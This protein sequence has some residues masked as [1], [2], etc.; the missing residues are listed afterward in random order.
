M[1]SIG[2]EFEA[3]RAGT[4]QKRLGSNQ[5]LPPFPSNILV[6]PNIFHKSTPVLA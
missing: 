6:S 4:L 3:A 5:L 1:D 2:V